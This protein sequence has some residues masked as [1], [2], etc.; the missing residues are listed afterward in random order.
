MHV[1][2]LSFLLISFRSFTNR[3]H[4]KCITCFISMANRQDLYVVKQCG[5]YRFYKELDV[6]TSV[7]HMAKEDT[8]EEHLDEVKLIILKPGEPWRQGRKIFSSAIDVTTKRPSEPG[9][10]IVHVFDLS[11]H[12]YHHR[13]DAL[14]ALQTAQK[15]C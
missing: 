2:R 10:Y 1:R 9:F 7:Q 8:E 13:D 4:Y 3:K 12:V 14:E 15:V 5:C 6:A 11:Y